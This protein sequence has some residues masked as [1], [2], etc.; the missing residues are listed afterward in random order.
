MRLL[1]V[2]HACAAS[3][4]DAEAAVRALRHAADPDPASD[5]ACLL[6]CDLPAADCPHMPGD[7]PIIRALQSGVMAMDSRRPGRFMLLVRS[8]VWCDA[9]RQ[10][11]GDEQSE[12][13]AQAV[14]RILASQRPAAPFA[15]ASVSP[16]TLPGK[17][18]AVLLLSAS[19]A[20]T[21]DTPA[22]MLRRM[23][24]LGADSLRGRVVLPTGHMDTPLR[25]LL[26]LGYTPSGVAAARAFTAPACPAADAPVLYTADALVRL[27]G[28]PACDWPMPEHTS[29]NALFL[30]KDPPAL[31]NVLRAYRID[32]LQSGSG[33]ALLPVVQIALL[34]WAALTGSF[35]LAMLAFL[36]PEL[37]AVRHPTRLPC[38]LI[39]T[40]LLP[41]HA[42]LAAD[43]LLAR[44]FACLPGFRIQVSRMLFT[45]EGCAVAGG[46]LIALGIVS[47]GALVP[48]M[49]IG[50][51]W[52]A[53][54]LIMRALDTP[55]VQRIPLT[56][57][58]A[59]KLRA[60]AIAAYNARPTDAPPA[61]CALD[62]VIGCMLGILEP[63]EAARIAQA[64]LERPAIHAAH[65]AAGQA[66]LLTAAQFFREHMA[67]CD[68]ALR[69][70]PVQLEALVTA[71]PM[72]AGDSRLAVFLRACRTSSGST[73]TRTLIRTSSPDALD[74]PFLPPEYPRKPY[75]DPRTLPLTHPHAYLRA[76]P[77]ESAD[78]PDDS[79]Y[80]CLVSAALGHPLHGLL[81]RSPVC[82][83]F[84]PLL[85]LSYL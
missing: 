77:S 28:V 12:T 15:A 60:A 34:F 51:L 32:C 18:D 16:E 37:P 69:A 58:E 79:A 24:S 3:V 81:L 38:A 71:M 21:P 56:D 54:P 53:A 2:L 45:A 74:F 17:F 20:C 42:A 49:F 80:L 68:A 1:I 72:P 73:A 36:L 62:A 39:R 48:L 6:L 25:R 84:A 78:M 46:L 19:L 14:A 52:L 83:P 33:A 35:V 23:V 82:A 5:T 65:S 11:L 4:A 7:A 70:L 47:A 44:A 27:A 64:Q 31:P 10:Y 29:D 30:W 67:D 41:V 61:A 40:A 59:A 55:A 13:P 76:L 26:A 57:A 66:S 63:D 43:A 22:R 75:A 50:L 9:A 85:F 8:R